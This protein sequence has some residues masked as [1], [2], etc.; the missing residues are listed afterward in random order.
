MGAVRKSKIKSV[1][2]KIA[3]QKRPTDWADQIAAIH[4]QFIRRKMEEFGLSKQQ[5][6]MVLEEMIARLKSQTTQHESEHSTRL[7]LRHSG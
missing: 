7:S 6:I 1:T 2:V 4:L 3:D 5:K